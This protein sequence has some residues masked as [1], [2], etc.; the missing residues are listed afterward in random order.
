M[1]G[2]SIF[3]AYA[4]HTDGFFRGGE[5]T[6]YTDRGNITNNI[7]LGG[8]TNNEN[9]TEA[10]L[11]SGLLIMAAVGAGYA[12]AR[13]KGAARK[14]MTMILAL[15]LILGMTQCKK[16]TVTPVT[17][18]GD[19]V[20]ITLNANFGGEKTG[21]NPTTGQ[22]VWSSGSTEYINVGGDK[23]GYIG[24]L[25]STWTAG[26]ESVIFS[27]D[28]TPAADEETLYFFYLGNGDHKEA[29]TVDFSNQGGDPDRMTNWHVAIGQAAYNATGTYSV[30]LNMAMAYAYFDISG[31]TNAAN[32]LESVYIHGD[33]VYSTATINYNNGTITGNTKGFIKLD[34]SI[35]NTEKYVALIPSV[36]TETTVKFDS[37]SKTGS[38]TFL[39][40]IKPAT[41]Y[42]NNGS[43][44]APTLGIL[45]EGATPG[46][47]TVA[48]DKMVRFSKGNLQYQAS[49]S[50][51][52]FA[53]NQYD[54]IGNNAGNS[55]F[56]E[57]RSTQSDWIDLF[58][59]GTSGWNNGNTYYMPYDWKCT[60]SSNVGYGYGPATIVNNQLTA[61]YS[62]IGDYANADW[63]IY[64]T[65]SNGGI[66]A[67]RTPTAGTDG[68]WEYL[69]NT[70]ITSTIN[71]TKNARYTRA[72]VNNVVGL[73]LFPDVYSQPSNVPNPTI[74]ASG[75]T[76][77][78]YNVTD[79]E[80]MESAGA[81]FLPCVGYR[82]VNASN[83]TSY[84]S[85]FGY[86][87]SSTNSSNGNAY[88]L[89]CGSYS[90]TTSNTYKRS[91]LPVR[92][93]K[94]VD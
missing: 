44:L 7:E 78:I 1:G 80:A 92:L 42:S 55:N 39:R 29:T 13:R 11:G 27:G 12:V 72:T 61:Q 53:E 57:T 76:T 74:A 43:A 34:R 49:T 84:S 47:F 14:G 6:D 2:V 94:D 79:W 64:N 24:Q 81:V 73:I 35:G 77:N 15:G 68:E 10:P 59:W 88:H 50:T 69:I 31:F 71:N 40:G 91:G 21:F 85:N 41:Y 18:A 63:G 9:P 37:N 17:P 23:S 86:Y 48:A 16:N 3:G 5:V 70:R 56:S 33:D 58:G 83:S 93:V 46:L 66:K 60:T 89:S 87:W 45:P 25:Q 36:T 30:T 75:W 38:M 8:V 19:S 67:W 52:R 20:H 26:F 28:I 90:V 62:L 82:S 22:F 54:A 32:E 65:I 51:W 4:Q